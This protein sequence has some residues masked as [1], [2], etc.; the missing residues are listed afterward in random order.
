MAYV[1]EKT[2][3]LFLSFKP[4]EL[5]IKKQTWLFSKRIDPKTKA[6]LP[7][8]YNQTDRVKLKAHEY[9]NE[10]DKYEHTDIDTLFTA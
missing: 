9:I 4:D 5:G 7:P 6:I 10:T 3:Q 2:K 1:D 8:R